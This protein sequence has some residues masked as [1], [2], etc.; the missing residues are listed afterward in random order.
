[1]QYR[2][3]GKTSLD[4]S[5]IGLGCVTFGREI[6]QAAS[7]AILNHAFDC[8]ITLLDTAASYGEGA[9]ETVLGHWLA[10]R[11]L[12]D[13]VVLASKVSGSM[14]PA[15]IRESVEGSLKRLNTDVIDLLQFHT[16]D[17]EAAVED[18]LDAVGREIDAGR[19]RYV[20]CSNWSARQLDHTLMHAAS[21]GGPR[22]ESVQPIYSLVHREIETGLLPLCVEQQVGVITYSPLGAG[23]LTGK[24]KR[25]G[26][27]PKGARFDIKPAHKQHYFTDDGWRIMESL[28]SMANQLDTTMARLALGWVLAQPGVTSMLIGAR[29]IGHIDQALEVD[30]NPLGPDVI[31]ALQAI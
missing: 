22:I 1:M 25:G 20:G 30:T 4:V 23:F 3:L 17:N 26:A 14:S 13:Q 29:K 6:D 12:R 5:A 19:V 8:G 9:S 21:H 11:R 28:R 16:W 10:E 18:S 7:F 24:Y 2:P 27:L 15:H 31:K